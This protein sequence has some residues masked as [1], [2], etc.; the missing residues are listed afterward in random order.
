M[1]IRKDNIINVSIKFLVKLGFEIDI[2][3]LFI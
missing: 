2:D 3:V 1:R